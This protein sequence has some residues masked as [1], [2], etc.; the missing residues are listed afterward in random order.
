MTRIMHKLYG[1][2]PPI[3]V[4][5]IAYPTKDGFLQGSLR[6]RDFTPSEDAGLVVTVNL[7][8]IEGETHT[9][10]IPVGLTRGLR[11]VL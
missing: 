7:D 8:I 9:S 6:N 5:G 2:L 4:V 11:K 1:E 3:L 10:V